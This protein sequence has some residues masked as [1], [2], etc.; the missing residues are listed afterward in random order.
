MKKYTILIPL[1]NDW[2]SISRLLNEIDLQTSKWDAEVSVLIVN[3]AS[4]EKR[5]ELVCRYKKLRS[6]KILNMKKYVYA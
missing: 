6:V 3:D 4:T 5:T 2:Q 1:F